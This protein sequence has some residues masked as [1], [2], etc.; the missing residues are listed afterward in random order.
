MIEIRKKNSDLR[1]F[2]LRTLLDP[3]LW[4]TVL[5]MVALMFHYRDRVKEDNEGYF[6]AAKWGI[7]TYIVGWLLFR[8]FDYMQKHHIIGI[9]IYGALMAVF[10]F[11]IR[12]SIDK[13]AEDY[14]ISWLLWFLTPQD[15]VD[16]NS[17][18]TLGFFILFFLFMA[19]VIYYFT[20]VRYRIF[21]NFLIF[22]IPFAIYGKE[23]E[24]MPTLFIIFLAV[25]YILLM[26][27][28]RQLKDTETTEFVGRKRSWKVIAAYAMAFASVAA[29]FPKPK[30]TADRSYLE[31]LINA[32][33]LTDRLD[34]MLNVFRNTSSGQQFRSSQVWGVYN[35]VADGPLRLKTETFTTYNYEKDEW[36]T[37]LVDRSYSDSTSGSPIDVGS[38]MGLADA[39]LEA[40]KLDSSFADK[41]GLEEYVENG[42]TVPEL[43]HAKFYSMAGIIG[44]AK[45]GDTA[46]VP[47]F[48]VKMTDCTR[49][50]FIGRLRGGVIDAGNNKSFSSTERFEFDY[51]EDTF[52]ESSE[53]RAFIEQINK[54]DYKTLLGDTKDILERYY[55]EDSPEK[56]EDFDQIYKYF[57]SEY[58]V[59]D[60]YL[61][62]LLDYGKKDRIK[63]LA[64]E[65]TAGCETEYEK[66]LKLE[67]YFYNND[68]I[69]DL[70]YKKKKGENAED[71][72]F[73]THTGVC[74]EY[75]TSMVLL[76]RAAGIPAR[77]CEGYN[78]T[79]RE[80]DLTFSDA[81]YYVTTKDAHGFPELY[82]KG[83]GWVSFEPTVT[84]EVITKEEG[85]ATA[86]L[87][88]AGLVI[89]LIGLLAVLF[90]FVYPWL[91]HKIFI[92]RSKKRSPKEFVIAAMHRICKIYDIEDVNTSKEVCGI[93][94]DATG[95]DIEETA[96]LFDRSVYGEK[97]ID[98]YEKQRALAEYIKA[99]EAF[100]ESRKRK[101][102]TNR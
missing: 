11:G 67:H 64:D 2:L 31:T 39:F 10:G 24:K 74:Y 16:Y 56:S 79:D 41:Y 40:A 83:Y 4:Y 18:Y 86:M 57:D 25:G 89:L 48:A 78:M 26:V 20:H 3:V 22:I 102:I 55:F 32:D 33:K 100:R 99:Y 93:V 61:T 101:G 80:S 28:Y 50:G 27:Y 43:K 65:I 52:F 15:S 1:S 62:Y 17:W 37:E 7:V 8:I 30:I 13:G 94:H 5:I 46:P 92:L 49:K 63:E 87:S 59:Y 66:A 97:Q 96:L 42:L 98:E 9:G 12:A 73:E 14:P 35:A 60:E 51:S 36:H 29:I 95:A 45:G 88:R 75:A 54:A 70:S 71:F 58:V 23:Y 69:Y 77:Y 84:D 19:S 38:R 21:M 82:I 44:D 47:Q 72:I 76:A 91:S 68:Y 53:N 34:A 81:N 85:S 90:I 6:F